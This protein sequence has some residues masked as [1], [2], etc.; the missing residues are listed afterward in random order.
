MEEH[1]PSHSVMSAERFCSLVASELGI[2]G[3][4]E[5]N[6]DLNMDL[7]MDS[8]QLLELALLLEELGCPAHLITERMAGM[9]DLGDVYRIYTSTVSIQ[10]GRS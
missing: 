5:L 8:L 3:H 1:I 4:I 6:S 9:L 7:Q 2:D 10:P